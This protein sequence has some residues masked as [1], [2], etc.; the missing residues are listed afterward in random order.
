MMDILLQPLFDGARRTA[1]LTLDE[2]DWIEMLLLG[3]EA[4]D[5]PPADFELVF[6]AVLQVCKK[7][8]AKRFLRG[9]KKDYPHAPYHEYNYFD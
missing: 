9:F 2:Y 1:Q 3:S 6:G 4:S 8:T 7:K 5:Y